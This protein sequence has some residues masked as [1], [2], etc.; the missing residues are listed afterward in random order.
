MGILSALGGKKGLKLTVF[1]LLPSVD[2]DSLI[3][4]ET[5]VHF[6]IEEDFGGFWEILSCSSHMVNLPRLNVVNLPRG[7]SDF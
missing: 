3:Q 2:P 6:L 4:S 7:S 1:V 5:S